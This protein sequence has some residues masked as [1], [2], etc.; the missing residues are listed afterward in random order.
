MF[1]ELHASFIHGV[2]FPD[3]TRPDGIRNLVSY[4]AKNGIIPDLGGLSLALLVQRLTFILRP[5]DVQRLW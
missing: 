2:P 1:P 4:F 5:E 3:H